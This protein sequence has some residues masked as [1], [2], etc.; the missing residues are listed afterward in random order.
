MNR[1]VDKKGLSKPQCLKTKK[2]LEMPY[3]LV[4]WCWCKIFFTTIM[5]RDFACFRRRVNKLYL[6]FSNVCNLP[7]FSSIWMSRFNQAHVLVI[8]ES[9]NQYMQD[10]S[11]L[12]MKWGM[13]QAYYSFLMKS[14][15][16]FLSFRLEPEVDF[17]N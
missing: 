14:W 11:R 5:C 3:Q 8:N 12:C 15:C 17:S 1:E 7:I 2:M 10:M 9:A 13:S 6:L 16:E 4:N